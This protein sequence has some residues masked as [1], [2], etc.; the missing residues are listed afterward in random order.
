ML[1]IIFTVFAGI[2]LILSQRHFYR[3]IIQGYLLQLLLSIQGYTA[4]VLSTE[5]LRKDHFIHIQAEY[6]R[7]QLTEDAQK[8]NGRYRAVCEVKSVYKNG[9]NI[10]ASG[11]ILC[12]FPRDAPEGS[13]LYG[14]EVITRF[15]WHQIPAP[16]SAGGFNYSQF[17]QRRQVYGRLFTS[18]IIIVNHEAGS[19]LLRFAFSLRRQLLKNL[20]KQLEGREYAVAAALLIGEVDDVDKEL[21]N[22]FTATGTMHVLSV[23]GMHVGLIYMMLA[24]LLGRMENKKGWRGMYFL[25]LYSFLWIYALITGFSAPVVRSAMML[26]LVLMGKIISR[27]SPLLNS[28]AGSCLLMLIYNPYWLMETG[29]QLSYMAVFGLMTIHPLLVKQL[30]LH[31]HYLHKIWE[32]ISVSLAAQLITLP[33]ILLYF[34]QFPNYFLISNLIIIPVSTIIIYA[35]I[36]LLVVTPVPV[37]ADY[38]AIIVAWLLKLLNGMTIFMGELP[39]AVASL[40]KISVASCICLYAIMYFAIKW[41]QSRSFAGLF[42]LLISIIVWTLVMI[43]KL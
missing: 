37:I 14:D 24:M 21:M 19:G 13:F 16:D 1:W 34:G 41:F 22:A 11:K 10:P 35:G 17:M 20:F 31:N 18:A 25:L 3:Y 33:A 26:S 43:L 7:L 38:I 36:I 30:N 40:G 29:F 32:L 42:I 39:G 23:S 4:V 28:L 8:R 5:N 15:N 27:K 9:V 2:I 12:Y 6:C